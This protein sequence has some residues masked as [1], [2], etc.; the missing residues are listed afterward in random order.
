M[1]MIMT[2]PMAAAPRPRALSTPWSAVFGTR[3][4][5]DNSIAPTGVAPVNTG[6]NAYGAAKQAAP[7]R[8]VPR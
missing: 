7:P 1:E 2:I 4:A 5:N 8:G 3:H 6:P